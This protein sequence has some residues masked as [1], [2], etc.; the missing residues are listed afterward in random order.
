M[1]AEVR[2]VAALGGRSLQLPVFPNELGF[3][4]YHDARYDPLWAAVTDA[5]AATLATAA[6]TVGEPDFAAS[7]IAWPTHDLLA[8]YDRYIAPGPLAAQYILVT[9]SEPAPSRTDPDDEFDAFF[10]PK[11]VKIVAHLADGLLREGGIRPAAVHA[12]AVLLVVAGDGAAELVATLLDDAVEVGA[13]ETAE[14]GAG[15]D[16]ADL[17]FLERGEYAAEGDN[18]DPRTA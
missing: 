8:V 13:R 18:A 12:P 7:V 5:W 10:T 9:D 6:H 2:R 17:H 14:L 11:S 16:A 15:A 3:P 4:D 1:V